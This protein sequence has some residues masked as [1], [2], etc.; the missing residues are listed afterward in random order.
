MTRSYL[1][2]CL[3][4]QVAGAPG[5][6]PGITGP[7]PDA[8]PLGHAPTDGLVSRRGTEGWQ[9]QSCVSDQ[10]KSASTRIRIRLAIE[11]NLCHKGA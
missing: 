11:A 7:K 9:G 10:R 8:L 2:L 6:E 1:A 4:N 5:F 3:E